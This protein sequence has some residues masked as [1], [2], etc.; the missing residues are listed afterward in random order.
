[1]N[2]MQYFYVTPVYTDGTVGREQYVGEVLNREHALNI[3][4]PMMENR[5]RNIIHNYRCRLSL[6]KDD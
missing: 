2:A 1:M 5:P 4:R 3:L 6:K